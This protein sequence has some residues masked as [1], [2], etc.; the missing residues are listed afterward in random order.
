MG[1]S[2]W[3]LL[4]VTYSPTTKALWRP[5]PPVV[6]DAPDVVAAATDAACVCS[7]KNSRSGWQSL[8][9]GAW[10]SDEHLPTE[11]PW[12][13]LQLRKTETEGW[14]CRSCSQET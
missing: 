6:G 2:F 13:R 1:E 12:G 9:D 8:K 14:L 11:S 5:N 3:V 4:A 10:L 7:V